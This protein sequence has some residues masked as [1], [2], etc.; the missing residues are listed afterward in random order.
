M[1]DLFISSSLKRIVFP[2]KEDEMHFT[3]P[4]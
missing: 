2:E 4:S 1:N 3:K